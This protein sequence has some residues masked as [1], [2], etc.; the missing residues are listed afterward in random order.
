MFSMLAAIAILLLNSFATNN[1]N[2]AAKEVKSEKVD[3]D[4][5]PKSL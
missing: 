2:A 4:V 1:N 3:Q 5:K